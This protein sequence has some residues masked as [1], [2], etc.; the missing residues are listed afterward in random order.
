MRTRVDTVLLSI[1]AILVVAGALVF[2]SAALGLLARGAT[3]ISAVVFNHFIL[4]IGS[5][6]ALLCLGYAI[7]Y[8]KWRNSAP[9]VFGLSLVATAL[10]FIPG[11]GFEHG[12]GRRWIDLGVVTL[13]P[14]ELLKLSAIIAAAALFAYLRERTAS[15]HGSAGFLCVIAPPAILLVLQPDLG[16]LGIISIAVFSIFLSAGA[17]F[18]DIML[19]IG[20]AIITLALL[21]LTPRYHYV[22]ERMDTFLHLENQ[23]AL[24]EGY[25]IHQSLIAIGSG[26]LTGR[27]F[28]QG[29][30]KF[31]YLPEP[32]GDSIFAVLAEETGF[33]GGVSLIALFLVLGL[34]GFGIA[35]RAP[36]LF[37]G[38]LAV[39]ISV[40]LV[41]E[42]FVNIA[43]MLALTPLTGI[44]LTFMSQGGSAMLASL[45]SAGIL[46]NISRKR[47]N[48][49]GKH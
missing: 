31:T 12:G 26:G 8:K 19:I 20:G 14:S 42:A 29:V 41:G 30:Q 22:Y 25:Q 11:L 3:H 37:G 15:W 44:P 49:A 38:L 21:T 45:L 1:L 33:F 35:A 10:V 17:R 48:I 47:K 9:Y 28:G 7:D 18:R 24:N 16:T 23:N 13:Q 43:A 2:S 27:G 32:M 34:R 39:G 36:D 46:L 40:Y 6:L 5:G 4:G